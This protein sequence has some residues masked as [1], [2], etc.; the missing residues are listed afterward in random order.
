MRFTYILA[1]GCVALMVSP[2]FGADSMTY[3]VHRSRESKGSVQKVYGDPDEIHVTHWE[4]W[5]QYSDGRIW[6]V[7]FG[8][9]AQECLKIIQ[10]D[11]ALSRAVAAQRPGADACDD[12]K[13]WGGR[14]SYIGPVAI[15]Y[16]LH[17]STEAQLKRLESVWGPLRDL[18]SAFGKINE[19]MANTPKAQNPYKEVGKVFK[20]YS[21][22]MMA[23]R[24][25]LAMMQQQLRSVWVVNDQ[26]ITMVNAAMSELSKR[27][28]T[29]KRLQASL[30]NEFASRSR[31]NGQSSCP[32]DDDYVCNKFCPEYFHLGDVNPIDENAWGRCIAAYTKRS[33]RRGLRFRKCAQY[34]DG[35]SECSD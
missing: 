13:F 31:S 8:V 34:S 3:Y 32:S 9:S 16:Q 21:E 28:G 35:S 25:T 19:I 18:M 22:Q 4:V 27:T 14:C 2:V 11:Q 24:N 30:E 26:T 7:S 6:G 15:V 29:A 1:L 33:D 5:W 20:E 12:S 23:S 10:E 17:S